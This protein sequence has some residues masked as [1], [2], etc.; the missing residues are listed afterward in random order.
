[1]PPTDAPAASAKGPKKPAER[2]ADGGGI[3]G[4]GNLPFFLRVVPQDE[5][6]KKSSFCMKLEKNKVELTKLMK[7]LEIECFVAELSKINEDEI[8]NIK[9]Y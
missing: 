5:N 1:V 9:R 7:D 4:E 3:R 6:D 8:I 2:L